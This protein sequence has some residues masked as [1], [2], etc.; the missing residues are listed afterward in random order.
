MNFNISKAFQI[1]EDKLEGWLQTLTE[2]L[3]NFVVAILVLIIFYFISR[4]VRLASKKLMSRF[5][6]QP[7]I[8]GLLSTIISIVI[9]GSGL[10]IALNL[11]HLSKA[12]TSLLAGAGIAGLAIGF[13]FQDI[14]A[15][16]I[17]GIIMAFRKPLNVGDIIETNGVTGFVKDIQ[18]RATILETFQ[19]LHVII[20]NRLIF[21]NAITNYTKTHQRRVDLYVGVSYAEDLEKVK[22]V[23]EEAVMKNQYLTDD[24]NVNLVFEGFGDS[25]INYRV[26]FWVNYSPTQ[27]NYLEARSEAIMAINKAYKEKG[28]T[29]PFPIRTLD[30][31]IKGGEKL[32]GHLKT[33]QPNS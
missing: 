20:P 4:I 27:P 13:A 8:I 9:I 14:S 26:M 17:S 5:I 1:V 2:M 21:Q 30:F 25:S 31:G 32:E 10:V 28:I 19:G 29:I 24:K 23:T 18:L 12:V 16:F 33:L 11:L 6:E 7:A 15:N 22:Q 3:P